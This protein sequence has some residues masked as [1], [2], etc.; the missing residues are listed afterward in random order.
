MTLSKQELQRYGRQLILPE[1]ELS[2]QLRLKNSSVLIAGLGGLGSP[3]ALYLAAAGVGRIGV[4]DYDTVDV[5]NLHRQILYSTSDIGKHKADVTARKLQDLNSEI[6]IDVWNT[7]LDISNVQ[8]ILN[9]YDLICD[10]ADN[11]VTRY[12]INDAA[13]FAKKPVVSAS[14]LGFEGQLMVL[15]RPNGPCYRC[16]YPEPPPPGTVPSC[17]EAG[18]LGVLPGVMGTLQATA[19]L[20]NILG[21]TDP[22]SH[23]L[24]AYNAKQLSMTN[25]EIQKNPDCP[26]CSDQARIHQV[27]EIQFE[28]SLVPSISVQELKKMISLGSTFQLLDVREDFERQI[29]SLQ[30]HIAIP[31]KDLEYGLTKLSQETPI[32]VYC[33]SGARSLR[34][35]EFLIQKGFACHNLEGGILAWIKTID[36]SL[37]SY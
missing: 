15:N 3:V 16:L 22:N 2:G 11:F 30:N 8:K 34:A 24:L 9:D 14:I 21:Q 1:L 7:R 29:C 33:K 26:L 12:L 27:S 25:L 10:G 37:N 17:A 32:I 13:Y 20:Q 36:P 31:M 18:V 28:C 4:L 23:Q 6:Q 5:S 35:C 19:A